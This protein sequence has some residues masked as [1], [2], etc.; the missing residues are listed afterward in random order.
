MRLFYEDN[1]QARAR[2]EAANGQPRVIRRGGDGPEQ[3]VW[4]DVQTYS[5]EW[6]RRFRAWHLE[7]FPDSDVATCGNLEMLIACAEGAE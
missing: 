1:Y 3:P 6:Y 4:D 7:R 2:I 5:P